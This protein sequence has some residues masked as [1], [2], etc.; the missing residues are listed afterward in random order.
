MRRSA[1]IACIFGTSTAGAV[2]V[3]DIFD[4][5]GMGW[6][7]VQ[8]IYGLDYVAILAITVVVGITVILANLAGLGWIG[9]S[10]LLITPDHGSRVRL[11]TVLTN[12][13]LVSGQRMDIDCGV[14]DACVRIC[15]VM[16]FT[17][18]YFNPS[19]PREVRFNAYLCY[20][21]MA[22]RAGPFGEEGLC[23]LCVYICP[24]T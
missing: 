10:C 16:A 9:K 2:I 15:P 24:A 20:S 5:H 22:K 7:T 13:P 4:Y 23:G 21:Y 17:G 14:C 11:A 6:F 8:A 12:A 1:L 3:E 19:E 18:V